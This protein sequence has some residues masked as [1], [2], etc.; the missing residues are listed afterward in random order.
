MNKRLLSIIIAVVMALLAVVMINTYLTREKQKYKIQLEETTVVVASQS[1]P[2]GATVLP[3]MLKQIRFPL[4]YIQPGVIQ[5]PNAAVGKIAVTDIVKDEQIL[6]SKLTT[7]KRT[8]D[9]LAVR[10]PT[11][12]RAFTIK[13]ESLMAVGGEIK[14]GDY[15]DVIGNFPYT[16]SLDGKAVTE[17]VTVTLFQKILVMGVN[18]D[19]DGKLVF[20]LALSPQ[21][22][23]ILSYAMAQG[24]LRFLLRQPLDTAVESVPPIEANALWQYILS[25]LGQQLMPPQ[26]QPEEPKV[27]MEQPVAMPV[28]PEP[29]PTLEIYRGGKKEEVRIK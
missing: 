19:S 1:I 28:T 26:Q 16:Q 29:E 10:L 7:I 8:E 3:N 17:N 22:S 25:T 4:Q 21:E 20:I 9:S 18:R 14:P 27:F 6:P 12:K 15:I 23:S 2:K 24:A 13:I 5:N 11:G